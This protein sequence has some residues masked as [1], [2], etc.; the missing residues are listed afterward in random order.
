MLFTFFTFIG[1]CFSARMSLILRDRLSGYDQRP[2][3]KVVE[4]NVS[5]LS[6]RRKYDLLKRLE[7]EHLAEHSKLRL[8]Y[9][10]HFLD[11]LNPYIIRAPNMSKGLQW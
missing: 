6:L 7:N 11:E 4:T 5:V 8:I 2:P 9:A 3:V 10:S 1:L